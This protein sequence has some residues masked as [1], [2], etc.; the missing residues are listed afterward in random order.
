MDKI[1]VI[2]RKKYE[3]LSIFFSFF[4]FENVHITLINLVTKL[5]INEDAL[6]E[7]DIIFDNIDEDFY[8]FFNE[9]YKI[10]IFINHNKINLFIQ[11]IDQLHKNEL[12]KLIREIFGY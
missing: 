10:C 1:K 2:E 9:K 7:L 6:T 12:V 8:Y 5:G 4:K 11:S 3:D